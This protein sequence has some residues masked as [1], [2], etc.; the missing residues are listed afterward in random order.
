[1]KTGSSVFHK[2]DRPFNWRRAVALTL[3]ELRLAGLLKGTTVVLI[4]SYAHGAQTPTSDVD[5]LLLVPRGYG[6]RKIT[7]PR[8]VHMQCQEIERF[9]ERAERG[10]DYAISALRFGRTLYDPTR[11]WTSVRDQFAV[12]RW[13]DWRDKMK[14]AARRVSFGDALLEAGD[15]D[16]AAEEYLL[17]ATQIGRALLLRRRIYPL[18]RPQL[19]SQLQ[20]AAESRLA[21]IVETLL[22][23]HADVDELRALSSALR[24]MV[25]ASA[26]S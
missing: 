4:G 2:S 6:R 3:H 1:M 10:D 15:I 21:E 25:V 17:A 5:I 18:S 19:V 12:S 11:L 23:R 20:A 7:A 16:A 24:G 8:S 14:Y 9:R 22:S 13:P 26:P